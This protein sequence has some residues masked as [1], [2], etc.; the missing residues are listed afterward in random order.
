MKE[1]FETSDLWQTAFML[2]RGC[3]LKKM[4]KDRLKP[5][6]IVFILGGENLERL[7]E[8]FYQAG[9]IPAL[10]Y[11]DCALNLKHSVF[12]FIRENDGGGRGGYERNT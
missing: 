11:R 6:R 9:E 5:G 1:E 3:H 2:C 10:T 8:N 7:A 4:V 12:K